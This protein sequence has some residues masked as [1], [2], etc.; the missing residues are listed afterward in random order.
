MER[1]NNTSD[2]PDILI[3]T[4]R[5]TF[6][7]EKSSLQ[8]D[9]T[10]LELK[11]EEVLGYSVEHSHSDFKVEYSAILKQCKSFYPSWQRK[12]VEQITYGR[13]NDALELLSYL[14]WA[15]YEGKLSNTT[16]ITVRYSKGDILRSSTPDYIKKYIEM[17][18]QKEKKNAA[19]KSRKPVFGKVKH[20][21][22]EGY[23]K[24]EQY[25]DK[26]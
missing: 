16:K 18:S 19:R 12:D 5:Y 21:D 20:R 14:K 6:L 15:E 9:V 7:E 3:A 10:T 23:A 24:M 22:V 2:S 11:I 4:D 25:I 26:S 17:K 8:K 1:T 13:L